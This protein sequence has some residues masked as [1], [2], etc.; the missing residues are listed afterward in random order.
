MHV[1]QGWRAQLP[2]WPLSAQSVSASDIQSLGG[3]GAGTQGTKVAGMTQTT[4]KQIQIG[5]AKREW[6]AEGAPPV[7][8]PSIHFLP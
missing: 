1:L 6:K 5:D 3:R 2:E 8:G 4:R 7:K